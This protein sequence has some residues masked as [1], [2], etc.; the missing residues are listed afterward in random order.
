[1]AQNASIS[2]VTTTTTTETSAQTVAVFES[3]A[4]V[5]YAD[6][7]A[8][9]NGA[10]RLLGRYKFT[11]ENSGGLQREKI[12]YLNFAS[13]ADQTFTAGAVATPFTDAEA[14][15]ITLL[16]YSPWVNMDE[17]YTLAG[18]TTGA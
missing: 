12:E 10:L 2:R 9:I 11:R 6:R 3:G 5:V 14:D 1:V 8:T 7:T 13:T 18:D 16:G 4:T 15:S 17:L